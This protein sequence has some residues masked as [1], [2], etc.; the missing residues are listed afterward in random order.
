M[1]TP[2]RCTHSYRGL[3]PDFLRSR[4]V[5]CTLRNSAANRTVGCGSF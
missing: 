1:S 5:A 2:S 3:I 4:S